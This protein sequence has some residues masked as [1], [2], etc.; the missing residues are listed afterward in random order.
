M[1]WMVAD[2]N[3]TVE[4]GLTESEMKEMLLA[5]EMKSAGDNGSYASNEVGCVVYLEYNLESFH[6]EQCVCDGACYSLNK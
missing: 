5:I 2:D 1:E 6:I 4:K 3:G